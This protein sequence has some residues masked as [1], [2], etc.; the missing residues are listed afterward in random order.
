MFNEKQLEMIHCDKY[1]LLVFAGPGSGKTT[2]LTSKVS[3]NLVKD[4]EDVHRLLILTFTNN[5]A[6]DILK[7]IQEKLGVGLVKENYY[8]GTFHSI[9]FKFLK[10]HIYLMTKYFGFEKLRIIEESEDKKI[11][12]DLLMLNFYEELS[13][14]EKEEL[15]KFTKENVKKYFYKQYLKFPMD[16]YYTITAIVNKAPKSVKEIE[17]SLSLSFPYT[18]DYRFEEVILKTLKEYMVQKIE[19]GVLSFGDILMYM[20][21]LLN[22]EKSFGEVLKHQFS[23]ILVDEFQDT[24]PIEANI[25][26]ILENDNTCFIGDPYQ[27]IYGFLGANVKNIIEKSKEPHMHVIQF[28]HNYRSTKNIVDFT[29]DIVTLFKYQFENFEPC[30]SVNPHGYENKKI[31]IFEQLNGFNEENYKVIEIVRK[32]LTY[33]KPNEIAILARTNRQFYSLEQVLTQ[34]RI[35]YIK[36]GGKSFYSINEVSIFIDVL[37]VLTQRYTPHTLENVVNYF[38]GLGI[39]TLSKVLSDFYKKED[40]SKTI[41]DIILSKYAKNKNLVAFS[42]LFFNEWD[43]TFDSFNAIIYHDFFNLIYKL[44]KDVDTTTKLKN[45]EFNIEFIVNEI[46]SLFEKEGNIEEIISNYIDNINL[47][48]IKD[49]EDTTNKIILSTVHAAKGLEWDN[50]IIIGAED[51]I[52]PH[53][54]SSNEDMDMDDGVNN[55]EEEKRLFYVAIS[56][57]KKE[58]FL[59]STQNINQFV[60]P[61]LKRDYLQV[62]RKEYKKVW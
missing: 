3:M 62:E 40:R 54:L 49:L 48:N 22:I 58:L 25:I 60:V 31:K 2:A 56:R 7:K 36:K 46:K 38:D 35:K 43:Y 32:L 51:D 50:C 41:K 11:F 44:K 30:M 13:D 53:K 57:A 37:K 5:A 39:T 10:E 18:L 42:E 47:A 29:N 45:V 27:S 6:N 21:L 15:G 33:N 55:I 1:P 16:I 34:N 24:N 12:L 8:I 28:V 4:K 14:D 19:L 17:E 59:T 23:N 26:E 20:Y 61:F 9:F 52:F